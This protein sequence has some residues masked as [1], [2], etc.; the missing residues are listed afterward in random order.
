MPFNMPSNMRSTLLALTTLLIS[1]GAYSASAEP[2]NVHLESGPE[3]V[4]LLELYT[5]EG[6][7]SCP[8]ADAWLG[9]LEAHPDLWERFVPV[10]FHVD[11]WNYLGWEDEWS[12][13]EHSKRQRKYKAEGGLASVYTPGF[14][15]N[16]EEWRG[17][18]K[19]KR[20]P[21]SNISDAGTLKVSI[22]DGAIVAAYNNQRYEGKKL[23]LNIALL[24]FD[25]ETSVAAGENRGRKLQHQFVVMGHEEAL[26][27]SGEWKLQLSGIQNSV[28]R[29]ALAVW[30]TRPGKQKPLQSV[31]GWLP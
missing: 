4:T 1:L 15:A 22:N 8:P 24:G 20:L 3:Q 7:S 30:V 13:A 10:A 27:K 29:N 18:F 23:Q 31:G 21:E 28:K 5:S 9:K 26:S 17:W 19:R 6:C 12:S 16:G 11:Y 25:I 2:N 14:V